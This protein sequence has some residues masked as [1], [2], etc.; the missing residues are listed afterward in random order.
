MFQLAADGTITPPAE[1]QIPWN[2]RAAGRTRFPAP[3]Q[4]ESLSMPSN[5]RLR[6]DDLSSS[7]RDRGACNLF[8]LSRRHVCSS[9]DRRV[10]KSSCGH[11]LKTIFVV[12]A[13]EQR[14]SDDTEAGTDPMAAGRWREPIVDRLRDAR[15]ETGVRPAPIVVSHPR[16]KHTSHVVLTHALRFGVF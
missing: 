3:P 11:R 13:A 8:L 1:L 7:L 16:G 10:P 5:Q 2:R 15:P 12:Q 9:N 14:F 6:L 4:P